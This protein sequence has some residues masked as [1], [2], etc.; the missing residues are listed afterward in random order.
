MKNKTLNLSILGMSTVHEAITAHHCDIRVFAFSL[1]TN[2]CVTENQTERLN[3]NNNNQQIKNDDIE[4]EVFEAAKT[5]EEDLAKLVS[6]IIIKIDSL[7]KVNT[8]QK[9]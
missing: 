1:I 8:Q 6:K 7:L 4:K 9:C 3:K 2:V 5:R